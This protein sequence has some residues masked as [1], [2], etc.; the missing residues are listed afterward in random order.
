[1]R[2]SR[3]MWILGGFAG[4][5][6]SLA[7][8]LLRLAFSEYHVQ[9]TVNDRTGALPGVWVSMDESD[10]QTTNAEGQVQLSGR[11]YKLDNALIT[12]THPALKSRYI[13]KTFPLDIS[14]KPW[15]TST[16]IN[17]ELTAV[18]G[19]DGAF[20]SGIVMDIPE[21]T[22]SEKDHADV[23]AQN[24]SF[25]GEV[26]GQQSQ[27]SFREEQLTEIE[28]P[29]DKIKSENDAVFVPS[30]E[31]IVSVYFCHVLEFSDDICLMGDGRNSP[32]ERAFHV[33]QA[34]RVAQAPVRRNQ[35]VANDKGSESTLKVPGPTSQDGATLDKKSKDDEGRLKRSLFRIVVT[36]EEKPLGDARVYMSRLKDN[37]I[38][39]LGISQ[40]DGSIES[41]IPLEFL[42]E[43]LTV[44]HSCCAPKTFPINISKRKDVLGVKAEMST[45]QG[46]GVLVQRE[47]YGHL[48]TF[49]SA[50]MISAKGKL[51]VTGA[52]GFVLHNSTKSP[53]LVFSKLQIR[54]A[55]PGE[56]V[57]TSMD[58]Q[59]SQIEP[60]N[61]LVAPEK[62]YLPALAIVERMDG[63]SFQGLLKNPDL[64]RWRRE[65]M[66]RLMHLQTV[67]S[68]VSNESEARVVAAGESLSDI[69]SRGWTETHLA[70]EW[71]F[72]LSL[73]Y[74][75]KNGEIKISAINPSGVEFFSR[76]HEFK[77]QLALIPNEAAMRSQKTNMPESAAF[78]SFDGFLQA[79]P[80]E[81]QIVEQSGNK[82]SLSF[83]E[84]KS[85][86]LKAGSPLA[87]YQESTETSSGSRL[88]ELAALAVVDDSETSKHVS[89][90]IKYWNL[91]NRKTQILP[92]VVRVA[93]VSLEFYQR[94]SMRRGFSMSS[95]I[96]TKKL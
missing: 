67:R 39:E 54:G 30:D 95:K 68:V 41:K 42:G 79:L 51:A 50:D 81:G 72:L 43:S 92:S 69:I 86:G 8:L 88:T 74:D 3:L 21:A 60:L 37:R 12:I 75:D 17:V 89:A 77:T 57:V 65:F 90:E 55:R 61:F 14:W 23:R 36:L 27:H 24:P 34:F 71:D 70:G 10:V 85:F 7:V 29:L 87:I 25:D 19:D 26:S 28:S 82:V 49:D 56:F 83:S 45:G 84:L 6:L 16:Q 52:D 76:K 4:L 38:R 64:R 46:Q 32:P 73:Q 9:V 59:K 5:T 35:S 13:S 1:M 62:N 53:E 48:R 58:A 47:A 96:Q 91:K 18:E 80:F 66:A 78:Q 33:P 93:K 44:F 94:E 20:E 40:S 15:Q 22:Q 31:L 63:K 11:R 2:S